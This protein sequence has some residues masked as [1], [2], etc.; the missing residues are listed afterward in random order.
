VGRSAGAF[1]QGGPFLFGTF[2]AADIIYAPVVSRF[3]SYGVPVPGFAV[4]YMQAIWDHEWV[5]AWWP[6]PARRNGRSNSSTGLPPPRDCGWFPA[7]Q[8]RGHRVRP[9]R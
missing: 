4:A 5:R 3:L 1:W 6:P 7:R 8:A 9:R 2:S